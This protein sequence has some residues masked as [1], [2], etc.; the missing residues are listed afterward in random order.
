MKPIHNKYEV[1]ESLKL[2]EGM[3]LKIL[4][5]GSETDGIQAVFEDIVEPGIGPE[6]HIHHKQD[7]TF[8][9]LEGTFDVEIDGQMFRMNA[10]DTAF[11]P[12]GTIHGWKNVGDDIG[13]LRYIYSP[14][15]NIEQM[16]RDIHSAQ[17]LGGVTDEVILQL[18]KNYPEQETVGPPL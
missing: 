18:A 7:E 9:F 4:L 12:K 8:I 14:A 15:L 16:F 11:I 1:V 2:F 3:T 10:G 6:R 17:E 5:S 13:R